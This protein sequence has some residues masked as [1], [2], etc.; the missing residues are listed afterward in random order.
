MDDSADGETEGCTVDNYKDAIDDKDDE[1]SFNCEIG[2]DID[3]EHKYDE[4][5]VFDFFARG[6]YFQSSAPVFYGLSEA[7]IEIKM[8]QID[9][10][11]AGHYRSMTK[12][13]AL[14]HQFVTNLI[15]YITVDNLKML[16]C[17]KDT[18]FNKALNNSVAAFAPTNKYLWN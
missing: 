17:D 10:H 13:E 3:S 6:T 15:N 8:K 5:D 11:F 7:E 18:C 9:R 12:H 4:D 1:E 2:S 16:D 14:Y